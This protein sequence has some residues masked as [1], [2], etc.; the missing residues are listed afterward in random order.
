MGELTWQ[1]LSTE[2]RVLYG[3][4]LATIIGTVIMLISVSTDH[5]VELKIPSG[6][7]RNATGGYVQGHHSGLWR[8]CRHE[9]KNSSV[10]VIHREYCVLLKLFPSRE[11]V[12]NDPEVDMHILNYSRTETAFAVIAL[13]LMCLGFVFSFYA[14]KEPRYMFKRLAAGMHGMTAVCIVVSAEVMSNSVEYE[15]EHLTSRHP[16]GSHYEFGYSY[17]LVWIAFVIYLLV[18]LLF[19]VYSRKRKGDNAKSEHEARE[20]EPVHLGRM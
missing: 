11:M 3:A 10:P 7:Y 19:L 17:V 8:I 14:I 20:N 6:Y 18:T 4:F 12:L 1:G 15:S 5:W 13:G 16:E 9:V 2:K